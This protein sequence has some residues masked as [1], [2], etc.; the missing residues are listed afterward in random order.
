MSKANDRV[1]WNYLYKVMEVMG[2]KKRLI[3]LIMQCVF[4][5]TFSVLV[6]GTSKGHIVPSRGLRQG[7]PLSPYLFLLCMEL[8]I[9][10]LS[11]SNKEHQIQWIMY[12]VVPPVN[13]LLFADD[14]VI[15]CEANEGTNRKT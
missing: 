7:D 4:T 11:T 10:L 13:H 15:F 3:E 5:T 2:F 12:A 6:N 14:S 1:E 9:F 8:F